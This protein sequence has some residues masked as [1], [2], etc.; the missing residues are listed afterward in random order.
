MKAS[1]ACCSPPPLIALQRATSVTCCDGG[2][3]PPLMPLSGRASRPSRPAPRCAFCSQEPEPA[4]LTSNGQTPV[5]VSAGPGVAVS[6]RSSWRKSAISPSINDKAAAPVA[7]RSRGT[8]ARRL[9][10]A[11]G[12]WASRSPRALSG[13]SRQVRQA[14]TA[15]D[16][17]EGNLDDPGRSL[18]AAG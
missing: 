12:V 6:S 8:L 10:S 18:G 11:T 4:R 7:T 15:R 9:G 17:P 5:Q 16:P 3:S 2:W 1:H 13:C 14:R